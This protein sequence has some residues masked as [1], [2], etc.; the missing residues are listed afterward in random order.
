MYLYFQNKWDRYRIYSL[1]LE[2]RDFSSPGEGI[3]QKTTYKRGYMY[4]SFSQF[5][6]W[7]NNVKPGI[8]SYSD[9]LNVG[10]T[11]TKATLS[12]ASRHRLDKTNKEINPWV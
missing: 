5:I 7:G 12:V 8:T 4:T 1:T 3:P 10:L 9:E 2:G 11:N 6:K